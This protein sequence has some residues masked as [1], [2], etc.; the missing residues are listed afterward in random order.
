V[1]AFI[2]LFS[3][4]PLRLVWHET[5]PVQIAARKDGIVNG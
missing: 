4:C 1:A 3:S 5:A 2:A